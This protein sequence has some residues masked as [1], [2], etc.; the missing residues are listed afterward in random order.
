MVDWDVVGYLGMYSIVGTFVLL[1]LVFSFGIDGITGGA[2]AV[3]FLFGCVFTWVCYRFY[4]H[5]RDTQQTEHDPNRSSRAS[6]F[7]YPN[8]DG[9]D[10]DRAATRSESSTSESASSHGKSRRTAWIETLVPAGVGVIPAVFVAQIDI[11]PALASLMY[12]RS[13]TAGFSAFTIR[14][15]GTSVISIG[16]AVLTG[17]ASIDTRTA[18]PERILEL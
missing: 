9:T 16:S 1:G 17:I 14:C 11:W 18:A 3:G 8:S 12:G 5:A 2:Y 7:T 4:L 13:A 10:S 15:A 6:E